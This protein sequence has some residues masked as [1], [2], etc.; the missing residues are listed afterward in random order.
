MKGNENFIKKSF[1]EYDEAMIVEESE[2][3]SK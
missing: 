1:F 3:I 2:R